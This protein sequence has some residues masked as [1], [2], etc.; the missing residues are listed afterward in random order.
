MRL[1]DP[2]G[3]RGPYKVRTERIQ[4]QVPLNAA[5]EGGIDQNQNE[6]GKHKMLD[7]VQQRGAEIVPSAAGLPDELEYPEPS[8]V[9]GLA[10]HNLHDAGDHEG[11]YGQDEQGA[12]GQRAIA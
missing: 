2:F 10:G 12:E 1:A 6:G 3:A 9:I 11:G 8:G 5:E 4:H 7:P